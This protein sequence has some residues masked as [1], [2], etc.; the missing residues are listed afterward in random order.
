[1][2]SPFRQH[3]VADTSYII[4]IKKRTLCF[5]VLYLLVRANATRKPIP[6]FC[7]RTSAKPFPKQE[8]I[9]ISSSKIRHIQCLIISYPTVFAT[10]I[11]T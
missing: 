2:A 11:S 8:S 3:N 9:K 1:M 6:C 7:Y 4:H 5:Y 10:A